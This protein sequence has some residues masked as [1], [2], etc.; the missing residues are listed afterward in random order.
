MDSLFSAQLQ[1]DL[2]K[3]LL[4]CA[5]CCWA[6]TPEES[7]AQRR[8]S[9]SRGGWSEIVD[10]SG[11]AT[12]VSELLRNPSGSP[13]MSS[14][15]LDDDSGDATDVSALLNTQPP[16]PSPPPEA[17]EFLPADGLETPPV[18]G[19]GLGAVG[20][21]YL[22]EDAGIEGEDWVSL[23]SP[24]QAPLQTD[25][26]ASCP[27]YKYAKVEAMIMHRSKPTRTRFAPFLDCQDFDDLAP[28]VRVTVGY[29]EDCL[30][31]YE[32]SYMGI[33]EWEE[34]DGNVDPAGNLQGGFVGLPPFDLNDF[35]GATAQHVSYETRLHNFEI[36]RRQWGWDVVSS[37]WGLRAI[38]LEEE[39]NFFSVDAA[40]NFE[41]GIVHH[42]AQ[43]LLLGAHGGGE[44]LWPITQRLYFGTKLKAGLFAN[45]NR[46]RVLI[47]N[48]NQELVKC[49]HEGV[50]FSFL[51]ETGVY[52]NYRFK[53]NVN[54]Y[55]GFDSF[56]LYGILDA[57]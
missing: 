26:C 6:F 4:L 22:G 10:D 39:L 12:D 7:N 19:P 57:S 23:H 31:G 41:R 5:V 13:P 52:L 8:G 54:L 21:D 11:D 48:D 42:K 50:D 9:G 56:Y 32:F 44:L 37:V 45:Y 14:A 53:K 38:H 33:H 27:A 49:T 55:A 36:N 28:G 16:P 20:G 40:P 29:Q 25:C 24:V 34:T 15:I 18:N 1:R 47:V 2:P 46:M 3:A 51:I 35:N 43:N 30:D 17:D